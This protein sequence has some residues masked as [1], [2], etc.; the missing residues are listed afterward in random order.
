MGFRRCLLS[1]FC[2]TWLEEE[3]RTDVGPEF[4]HFSGEQRGCL[5]EVIADFTEVL[6]SHSGLAHLFEY[7][8]GCRTPGNEVALVNVSS[9]KCA[10]PSGVY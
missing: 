5:C 4:S 1:W 2:Q 6:T 9:A 7:N 3:Q 8:I 10:F